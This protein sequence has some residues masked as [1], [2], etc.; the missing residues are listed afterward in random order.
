MGVAGEGTQLG[1]EGLDICSGLVLSC[2]LIQARHTFFLGFLTC[3]LTVGM[4][5][6]GA[7]IGSMRGARLP[8]GPGVGWG[9]GANRDWRQGTKAGGMWIRVGMDSWLCWGGFSLWSPSWARAEGF[10]S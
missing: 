1:V 3:K 10:C 9:W 4:T 2:C 6:G 7:E 5:S 8:G